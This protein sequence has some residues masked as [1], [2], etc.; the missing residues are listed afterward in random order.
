M[1]MISEDEGVEL[2]R[3]ASGRRDHGPA[4]L[5]R[6]VTGYRHGRSLAIWC[7]KNALVP[8]RT[9]SRGESIFRSHLLYKAHTEHNVAAD[10][11]HVF[12]NQGFLPPKMTDFKRREIEYCEKVVRTLVTI[13]PQQDLTAVRQFVNSIT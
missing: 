2:S 3:T 11:L 12:L 8:Q 9:L 1:D 10:I 13:N 7:A 4:F 5:Y 6:L